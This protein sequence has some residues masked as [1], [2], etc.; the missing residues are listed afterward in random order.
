MQA[1]TTPWATTPTA[2]ASDKL[3]MQCLRNFHMQALDL[4]HKAAFT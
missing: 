3:G 4:H 2:F 1:D